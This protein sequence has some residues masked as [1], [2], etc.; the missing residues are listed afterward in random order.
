[1]SSSDLTE[2]TLLIYMARKVKPTIVAENP[3]YKKED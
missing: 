1:M 2:Q 3:T